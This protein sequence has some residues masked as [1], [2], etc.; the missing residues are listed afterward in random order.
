M[1]C[2]GYKRGTFML[3]LLIP[4]SCGEAVVAA[5]Q[6][7]ADS[8]Y[9]TLSDVSG[10]PEGNFPGE[11]FASSLRYCRV[12]G[13]KV[14]IR[15]PFLVREDELS[16][17]AETVRHLASDGAD[18]FIIGDLGLAGYISMTMPDVR[19]HAD[20]G[21]DVHNLA[22][23]EALAELGF[24][25]ACLAPELNMD[26]LKYLT[27]CSPIELEISVHGRQCAAR[28]GSCH[29]SAL[30]GEGS[31]ARGRCAAPCRQPLSMGGRMDDYPL[32]IKDRC[33][34]DQILELAETSL[35]CVRADEG[36]LSRAEYAAAAAS[37][38]STAVKNGR[39]PAEAEMEHLQKAFSPSGFIENELTSEK[40]PEIFGRPG[41]PDR[42]EEK[43][44][45]GL[46]RAYGD[47]ELRRVGITFY[48]IVRHGTRSQFAAEDQ[49][50]NRAKITG[51][52]PDEPGED[53]LTEQIIKERFYRT[54]GTPYS[55]LDVKVL[56]E[57]GVC[58]PASVINEARA[59]LI[60]K[61]TE[62][63]RAPKQRMELLPTMPVSDIA[64]AALRPAAIFQVSN[65]S[66]LT[67]ELAN[68]HPE[69]I[70]VPLELMAEDFELLSPFIDAGSI[71]AAVMP[72]VISDREAAQVREKL[73]KVRNLGVRQ[74][75]AGNIG[76]IRML[77]A[78]GMTV[79]GDWGFNVFNS[80][81]LE[82]LD[83]A[84]MA[85]ATLSF[86]LSLEQVSRMPKPIDT[87]IIVYGRLPVMV[88]DYCLIKNSAGR[89]MC[90]NQNSLSN[91][92]GAVYPVMK[93]FGCRNILYDTNKLF[94]GDKQDRY[95]N[96]GLWGARLMF[97]TESPAE[98]VRVA[99]SYAGLTQYRPNSTARGL[100]AKGVL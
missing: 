50:G 10:K 23:I 33:L 75:L 6:S 71:P 85:S 29:M 80:R 67:E 3:E 45:N 76:H 63:R 61:I 73:A 59:A 100:Y 52:E 53:K 93:Q 19:M 69:Y 8:I 88:T 84:A 44:L 21:L 65:A 27:V 70:Y 94:L 7:G 62:Q 87:E 31:K 26:E 38:Y 91:G 14:Y 49:D 57:P 25:R 95:S 43:Y 30:G 11:E 28:G 32:N 34:I 78:A 56:T 66:Q 5:V 37:A 98:C 12:R 36:S 81:T 47:S 40:G 79:R 18:A 68:L 9:I 17:A 64:S 16:Q 96:C 48:A 92:G 77:R 2:E 1:L 4:A 89:C 35:C 39:V 13:C 20:A 15:M 60:K 86:E 97:T 54:G 74:G 72:P 83:R 99:E 82:I 90:H 22:G 51:P 41:E 55:C 58:M 46:R 24:K 42:D